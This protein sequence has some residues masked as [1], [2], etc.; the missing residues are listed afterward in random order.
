[1]A[2]LFIVTVGDDIIIESDLEASL[3]KVRV[4]MCHS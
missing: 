1:M 3:R 2:V 4:R